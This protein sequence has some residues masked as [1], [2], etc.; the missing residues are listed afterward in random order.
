MALPPRWREHLLGVFVLYHLG[1]V[2]AGSVPAAVGGLNR[3]SWKNPTVA[4]ELDAW[5]ETLSGVGMSADREAFE[6]GLYT[7]AVRTV[8]IQKALTAPFT[9]YYATVGTKQ[10]WRMFV[11]PMIRP[12]A[13]RIEGR[14]GPDDAWSPLYVHHSDE[15]DFAARQLR[16]SRVRPLLFELAW[17]KSKANW[18]RFGRFLA[19]EAFEA[20]PELSEVQLVWE[21]RKSPGPKARQVPEPIRQRPLIFER[22]GPLSHDEVVP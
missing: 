21:R 10:S 15:H 8:R 7:V 9:H 22:D 19:S 18:T 17:P 16:Y 6:D 3:K 14:M 12:A 20:H 11:A 4:A 2:L 13:L 1:A 5:H